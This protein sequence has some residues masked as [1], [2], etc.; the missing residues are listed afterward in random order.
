MIINSPSSP[1]LGPHNDVVDGDV[2]ELHKEA[3]EA[4]E[5]KANSSCYGYLS[6]FL[7]EKSQ[8]SSKLL[9]NLLFLFSPI[10]FGLVHLLTSLMEFLP[11]CWRGSTAS[12]I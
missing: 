2:D 11:N 1:L 9:S 8:S 6:E 3:N 4:H 5:T 10:R 12:V 7:S